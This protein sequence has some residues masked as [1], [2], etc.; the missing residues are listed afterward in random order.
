MSKSLNA[1]FK[2]LYKRCL[3]SEGIILPKLEI[4][5]SVSHFPKPEGFM[6]EKSP[7]LT[8]RTRR[9]SG[10]SVTGSFTELGSLNPF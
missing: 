5:I 3:R 10:G 1:E 8:R 2:C 6:E 4:I 9:L 7:F